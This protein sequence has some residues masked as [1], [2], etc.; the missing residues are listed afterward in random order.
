MLGG[1]SSRMSSGSW[2]MPRPIAHAQV[3][4]T[5]ALAN[6]GFSGRISQSANTSRGSR[7]GGIVVLVPSGKTASS[8]PFSLSGSANACGIWLVAVTDLATASIPGAMLPG[9]AVELSGSQKTISS[10]HSLVGL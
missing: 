1:L 9:T 8:G 7:L 2:I 6:Q 10:F 3:R 5:M 4:L